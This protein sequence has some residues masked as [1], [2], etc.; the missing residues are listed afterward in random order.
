[1]VKCYILELAQIYD[2]LQQDRLAKLKAA[3]KQEIE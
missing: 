3:K 2:Q 1:V